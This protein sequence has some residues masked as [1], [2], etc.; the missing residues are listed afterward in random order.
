MIQNLKTFIKFLDGFKSSINLAWKIL[1]PVN[2]YNLEEREVSFDA[3]F[4]NLLTA[5]YFLSIE[6]YIFSIILYDKIS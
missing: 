1:R 4:G 6:F 5:Y 3:N 2:E